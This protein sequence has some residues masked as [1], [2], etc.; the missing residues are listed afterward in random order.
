[1]KALHAWQMAQTHFGTYGKHR[2]EA[3]GRAGMT[4]WL[5]ELRTGIRSETV[6][7]IR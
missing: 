1:M 5:E 4:E 3:L 7:D 6:V 2:E